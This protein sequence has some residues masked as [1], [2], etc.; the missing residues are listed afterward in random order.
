MFE[1]NG[2]KPV[3]RPTD[4]TRPF[5]P[6]QHRMSDLEVRMSTDYTAAV[7]GTG[8]VSPALL[9]DALN[10]ST[11]ARLSE[12]VMD[13]LEWAWRNNASVTAFTD[14]SETTSHAEELL[15]NADSAIGATNITAMIVEERCDSAPFSC[16]IVL[17]D[18][19]GE[20]DSDTLELGSLCIEAEIPVYD[21]THAMIEI[22]PYDMEDAASAQDEEEKPVETVAETA[23]ELAALGDGEYVLGNERVALAPAYDE[24]WE[25]IVRDAAYL[26]TAAQ[27]LHHRILSRRR[28]PS[29]QPVAGVVP[30]VAV[31]PEIAEPKE[32][33]YRTLVLDESS[34]VWKPRG[35]GRLRSAAKTKRQVWDLGWKDWIDVED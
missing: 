32:A 30:V 31:E 17:P 27:D 35:R 12:G 10:A 18:E 4:R 33:K 14:G 2:P 20:M 11:D 13:V 21:L 24:E 3:L 22:D 7:S 29:V 9:E 25:G 23:G 15:E 6:V 16:L 19:S 28:P 26:L 8:R 1:P 5:Q 34:G